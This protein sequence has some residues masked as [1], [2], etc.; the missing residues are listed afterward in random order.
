M[1]NCSSVLLYGAAHELGWDRPQALA[2]L[3]GDFARRH[4]AFVVSSR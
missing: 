1:P 4:E 3:L 2:A